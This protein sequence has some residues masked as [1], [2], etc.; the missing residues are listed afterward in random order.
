ML[1]MIPNDFG[2]SPVFQGDETSLFVSR[3]PDVWHFVLA[4]KSNADLNIQ[5]IAIDQFHW[6]RY[7]V[8]RALASRADLPTPELVQRLG[9]RCSGDVVSVGLRGQQY[10]LP[11]KLVANMRKD[12]LVLEKAVKKVRPKGTV[13]E[14]AGAVTAGGFPVVADQR[15]LAEAIAFERE[16]RKILEARRFGTYSAFC[17][18]RD[19]LRDDVS[20]KT[21]IASAIAKEM[22]TWNPGTFGDAA[23]WESVFNIQEHLWGVRSWGP[24]VDAE[25]GVLAGRFV[26]AFDRL[27]LIQ[28]AQFC[29]MNGMHR[30]G[31]FH[32]LAVLYGLIDFDGYKY[33]RTSAFQPDSLEE[34]ELRTETAFIELLGLTD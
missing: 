30:G 11:E 26:Q 22:V 2:V 19:F 9:I 13:F 25:E 31:P 33:W 5:S 14:V 34:Q 4:T 18:W 29:L 7:S 27:S 10:R 32:A 16:T 6:P 23:Y 12:I 28:F 24:G 15:C 20:K 1:A 17:T 3:R 21:D 8:A